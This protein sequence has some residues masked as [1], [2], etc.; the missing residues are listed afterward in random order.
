MSDPSFDELTAGVPADANYTNTSEEELF[1]QPAAQR[2][3]PAA[4]ELLEAPIS[5]SPQS[6]NGSR[7]Q[8]AGTNHNQSHPSSSS[9]N[10]HS[11][12]SASRSHPVEEGSR[13]VYVENLPLPISDATLSSWFSPFGPIE[14]VHIASDK[15]TGKQVS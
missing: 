14:R 3:A 5:Y 6:V 12:S 11:S 1:A 7:D 10:A 2:Q 4:Q 13:K 15:A 8:S 9:T